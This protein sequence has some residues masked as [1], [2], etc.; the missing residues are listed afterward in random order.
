VKRYQALCLGLIVAGIA[1]LLHAPLVFGYEE[2]E[3]KD[4][5]TL[6]GKVTLKGPIPEARAFPG[7]LFPFF[8]FCQKNT[9]IFVADQGNFLLREVAL[10]P[11]Q[12]LK[13]V[14]IAVENVTKGKHFEPIIPNLLSRDC[15]FLPFVSVVQNDS[16]FIMKNEDPVLHNSQIYQA[17]KGNVILNVPVPPHSI[18]E[19]PIRFEQDRRIY[20][21]ICGM[22]E[23]MH[24]WGFAVDNPYYA[25]TGL[26]GSFA[27]PDLPPG[28][29]K[30][31]AWHPRMKSIEREITV[32]KNEKVQLNFEYD[33]AKLGIPLETQQKFRISPRE[34]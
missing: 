7:V 12:G 14:V 6:T 25:L 3:V 18:K 31:I 27:I 26:D 10:G 23:F 8:K 28:T 34:K 33:S 11:D 19:H 1:G 24:T 13:D 16:T 20:Q 15:E 21:M 29:Y 17:E 2:I 5:G 9:A 32:S 22:H 30:V 4:G